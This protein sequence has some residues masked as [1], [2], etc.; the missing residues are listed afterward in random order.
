V[1]L[2]ELRARGLYDP[3]SPTASERM[4][5]LRFLLDQGVTIDELVEADRMGRLP[6]IIGDRALRP[7]ADLTEDEVAAAAGVSLEKAA[8]LWRACGFPEPE[9]DARI[10]N[11]SD[12]EMLRTVTQAEELFG[13][14][15]TLQLARVVASSVSRIAEAVITAVSVNRDA[16]LFES[17]ASELELAQSSAASGALLPQLDEV[18]KN[19]LRHHL[20]AINNARFE[21]AF[22]VPGSDTVDL[23][24]GFVDLVGSTALAQEL[25]TGELARVVAEFEGRASDVVVGRGGRV[26]KLI[27]DEVMFVA[28]DAVS[29]CATILDLLDTFE[30]DEVLPPLRGGLAV[31]ELLARDGDYY[32]SVVSLASRAV[33]RAR[34][35]TVLVS[36]EVRDRAAAESAPYQFKPLAPRRLKGFDHRVRLF[37][38]E[39]EGR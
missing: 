7:A 16:P 9:R 38:L 24:V 4:A 20:A 13:E 3:E 21:L 34:P 37:V 33:T 10:F 15:A 19:L 30:D 27:G 8:R 32:G 2:D 28:G 11:H 36:E 39:R 14:E 1:D 35:G 29:A 23:A 18:M 5:V 22:P 17:G 26:V 25:S 31:G 6:G 12:V